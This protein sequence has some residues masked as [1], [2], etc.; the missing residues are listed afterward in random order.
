MAEEEIF[1][2]YAQIVLARHLLRMQPKFQRERNGLNMPATYRPTLEGVRT[3]STL[4]WKRT[5]HLLT[6]C[7]TKQQDVCFSFIVRTMLYCWVPD[8]QR[9]LF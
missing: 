9:T 8:Q 3:F 5:C 6:L 2:S 7:Q 1:V 4:T